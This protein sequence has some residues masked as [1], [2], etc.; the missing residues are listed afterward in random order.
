MLFVKGKKQRTKTILLE[1]SSIILFLKDYNTL[2][3][4]CTE[5]PYDSLKYALYPERISSSSIVCQHVF[6]NLEPPP[7]TKQML[8]YDTGSFSL[9]IYY[10]IRYLRGSGAILLF[11]ITASH[12][13]AENVSGA[14]QRNIFIGILTPLI[15]KLLTPK[16]QNC[17]LRKSGI[18]PGNAAVE[19]VITLED[20][21]R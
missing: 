21:Q 11:L 4:T 6:Q 13:C 7:F 20:N 9:E 5:I 3:E 12:L 15:K 14:A 17:E 18:L 1:I 10:I 19:L 16:K 8:S 2:E